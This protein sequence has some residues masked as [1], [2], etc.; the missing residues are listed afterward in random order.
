MDFVPNLVNRPIA[1]AYII[2]LAAFRAGQDIQTAVEVAGY[3]QSIAKATYNKIMSGRRTINNADASAGSQPH[4]VPRGIKRYVKNCMERATEVKVSLQ[5]PTGFRTAPTTAGVVDTIGMLA[6]ITQGTA[7]GNRTG[8]Q[9]KITRIR[10]RGYVTSIDT[11]QIFRLI[12]FRDLQSNGTAPVVTDVLNTASFYDFY[13][14]DKVLG[15]G[16]TRFKILKDQVIKQDQQVATTSVYVPFEF[17]FNQSFVVTY[18]A[19]AGSYADIVS[20]NVWLLAIC[21]NANGQYAL[22]GQTEF[23]DI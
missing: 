6:N 11:T 14:T 10:L 4:P 5:P 9:V 22:A 21:S 1:L 19:T 8:N 3:S 15:H 20:N 23:H 7:D 18:S 2:G 17:D 12:V 13:N 16:G